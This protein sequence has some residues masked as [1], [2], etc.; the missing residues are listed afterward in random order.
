MLKPQI[1]KHPKSKKISEAARTLKNKLRESSAKALRKK[2]MKDDPLAYFPNMGKE[3]YDTRMWKDLR[4]DVL[5]ENA[6]SNKDGKAH[7]VLCG[8]WWTTENPLHVDH[9]LPRSKFPQMEL[10]KSNM[11]V[12]CKMCNEGKSAKV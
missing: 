11:Q 6:V 3:F 10:M 9:K 4:F 2:Q 1:R 5:R 8:A 7:C 12:L